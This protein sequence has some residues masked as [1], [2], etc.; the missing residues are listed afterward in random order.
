MPPLITTN[1]FLNSFGL[2]YFQSATLKSANAI[3]FMTY[4]VHMFEAANDLG[5]SVEASMLALI[6]NE[7]PAILCVQDFK[8]GRNIIDSIKSLVNATQFYD[9][10]NDLNVFPTKSIATFSTYPIV[11]SGFIVLSTTSL[12]NEA[13]FTDINTN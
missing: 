4:N 6:K 7:K 11:N 2:N 13:I 12:V 1:I 10:P 5:E 3:K 8:S 9:G